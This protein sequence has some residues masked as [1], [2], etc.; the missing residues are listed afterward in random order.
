MLNT[1]G[2]TLLELRKTVYRGYKE[3][4][5]FALQSAYKANISPAERMEKFIEGLEEDGLR[6]DVKITIDG[7]TDFYASRVGYTAAMVEELYKE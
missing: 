2:E 1:K 6:T 7:G 5:I 3:S 4:A